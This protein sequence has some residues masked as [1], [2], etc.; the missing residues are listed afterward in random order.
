MKQFW[1]VYNKSNADKAAKDVKK[2]LL[3]Y[4]LLAIAYAAICATFITV[5]VVAE[6]NVYLCYAVNFVVTVAFAWYTVIFFSVTFAEKRE[7]LRFYR[8]VDNALLTAYRGK[9]EGIGET[10]VKEGHLTYASVIFD[11]AEGSKSFLVF[12]NVN[13]CLSEGVTYDLQVVGNKLMSYKE[14]SND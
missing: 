11:T 12:V 1:Q 8:V 3:I 9:F 13:L 5:Y 4:I 7:K 2:S 6:V 10:A 14:F